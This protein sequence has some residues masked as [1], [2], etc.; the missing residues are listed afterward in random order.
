MDHKF[1]TEFHSI[2]NSVFAKQ[3]H[4]LSTIQENPQLFSALV[5]NFS[6]M[7]KVYFYTDSPE[8]F[9]SSSFLYQ[10]TKNVLLLLYVKFKKHLVYLLNWLTCFFLTLYELEEEMKIK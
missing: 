3:T 1:N 4:T 7:Y 10:Y 9:K 6:H 2:Q 8:F 5:W